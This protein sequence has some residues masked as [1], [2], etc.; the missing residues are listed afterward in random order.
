MLYVFGYGKNW[1]KS[2]GKLLIFIVATKT[3]EKKK[4]NKKRDTKVNLHC[5]KRRNE[6]LKRRMKNQRST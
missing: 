1:L 5:E 4:K 3:K 6:K 2:D